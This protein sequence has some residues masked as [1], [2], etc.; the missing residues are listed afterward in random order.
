MLSALRRK[1]DRLSEMASIGLTYTRTVRA[2]RA[3][4]S[5]YA[6]I[7]RD[8]ND[9][10]EVDI[11]L[12]IGETTRSVRLRKAD[13]FTLAEVLHERQYEL[14]SHVPARPMIMDAGANIGLATVWFLGRYPGARV[15]CFEPDPSNAVLLDRNVGSTEGVVVR[16][17]AV[18]R[19][20]GELMLHLSPISAMH[21]LKESSPGG[22][23]VPVKVYALAG[24]LRDNDIPAID[25]LKLD[26]EGSE[27][28]VL[29]GLGDRLADVSVIVGECHETL[30]DESAFYGHLARYGFRTVRRQSSSEA[31]V[32]LFE[33]TRQAPTHNG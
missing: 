3:L 6:G 14:R 9:Q 5:C 19:E 27:L 29:Q 30:V 13:I 18:G 10:T 33:V 22:R 15:H 2:R 20:D 24:Y 1:V 16:Q 4:L 21:S 11:D 12:T 23:A 28:D 8:P 25:V 31:G 26:V 17:A 32:H 7:L